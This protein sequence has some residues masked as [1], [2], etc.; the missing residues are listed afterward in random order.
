[1]PLKLKRKLAYKGHYLY[2]Y[3]TP[4]KLLDALSFLKAN[5]PWYAD[6]DVNQEW[7]ESAVA[8]CLVEQCNDSDEQPNIDNTVQPLVDSH[9]IIEP[10]TDIAQTTVAAVDSPTAMDCSDNDNVVTVVDPQATVANVEPIAMECLENNDPLL[11]AI[12]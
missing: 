5:N 7:L 11:T 10:P 4:Q 8:E 9:D 6:I 3:I 1:M 12:S 2:D